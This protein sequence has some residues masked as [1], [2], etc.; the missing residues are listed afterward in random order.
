[1]S[2]SSSN[3]F[4]LVDSTHVASQVL[5]RDANKQAIFAFDIRHRAPR[6]EVRVHNV[7]KGPLSW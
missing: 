5:G 3:V 7:S 2:K 1:M 4:N 6:H